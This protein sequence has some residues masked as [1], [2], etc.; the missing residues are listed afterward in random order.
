MSIDIK[1]FE[2]SLVHTI[3]QLCSQCEL[4][5]TALL[6][7]NSFNAE[8]VGRRLVSMS[9]VV[10]IKQSIKDL[11]KLKK[12]VAELGLEWR[13]N[14]TIYKW[15]GRYVGDY[16]LP[17]GFTKEEL[18]KCLH[19]FGIPNNKNAYE[20]GVVQSKTG[21]GYSLLYDFWAGGNGLA[22]VIGKGACDIVQGYAIQVA[23]EAAPFGWEPTQTKQ[24][25][26]DI[27]L[28]LEHI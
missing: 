25:N 20:V 24:E 5:Q 15:Y 3:R 22:A 6:H 23:L 26:G 28:E 19:A 4:A 18:G 2:D 10:C 11:G 13:E 16:P 1:V 8:D 14:Q 27:V 17:D 7:P 12:V 9:H 21:E